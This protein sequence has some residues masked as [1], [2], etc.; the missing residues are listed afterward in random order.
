MMKTIHN[1]KIIGIDHGYGNMKTAN[2]CFLSGILSFDAEPLFTGGYADLQRQ[3]LSHRRRTQRIYCRKGE[4]RGLLY[5]HSCGHRQGAE[6]RKSY[7][8]AHCDCRW[9]AAD[10]D[11]RTKGGLQGISDEKCRGGVLLTKRRTTTSISTM[12]AL[13]RRATPPLQLC[14]ITERCQ[15]DC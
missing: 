11:K 2:H 15:P 5:P 13:I 1:T 7:R 14:N 3:V 4:R 8:G 9:S 10:L 6:S 12:C